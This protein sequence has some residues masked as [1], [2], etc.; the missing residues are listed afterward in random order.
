MKMIMW[1]GAWNRLPGVA[2]AL[3]FWLVMLAL[4]R[5]PPGEIL[6]NVMEF[7][8]M[9]R[10]RAR[11]KPWFARV[12]GWLVKNGAAYHLWKNIAPDTLL[13]VSA[14]LLLL[15]IP[16]GTLAGPAAGWVTGIALGVFPWIYIPIQNRRDNER[17]LPELEL[18]YHA[19]AMQ[20]RSGIYVSDALAECYSGVETPRL[21]DGL[22][23][24]GS[25]I[26]LKSDVY[27]ALDRFQQRFDN[28]YIDSLC[29]TVCQALESG[30]AVELLGDLGEQIRDMEKAVLEKRKVSLDRSITFYQLG[31][32]SAVLGVALY[33]CVRYMLT[34]AV[35]FR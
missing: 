28:R 19:L 24:L 17:M 22:M 35:G 11:K 23:E 16:V 34:E 26:V 33:S 1:E 21:R 2:A 3:A 15:G 18:I 10:D 12:E 27:R 7:E 29:I 8:G 32:L 6:K 20:I 31:I 25:D 14:L 13:A 5:L 4:G 30:Q 9:L